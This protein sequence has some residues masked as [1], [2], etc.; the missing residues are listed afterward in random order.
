MKAVDYYLKVEVDLPEDEDA[1][2][3]AEELC[4]QL[5]KNYGVRKAELSSV[6][7]HEK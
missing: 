3:Y 2:R 7:E 6:T 4:R 1:R 5:R